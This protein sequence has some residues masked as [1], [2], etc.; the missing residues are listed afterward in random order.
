MPFESFVLGRLKVKVTLEG[1]MLNII[2]L[3]LFGP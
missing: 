1:H 2:K 3:S